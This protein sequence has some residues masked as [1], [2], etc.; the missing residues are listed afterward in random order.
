MNEEPKARSSINLDELERQLREASRKQAF[1]ASD[2]EKF[3][4][5]RQVDSTTDYSVASEERSDFRAGSG[6]V[7]EA[8]EVDQH[9]ES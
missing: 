8:P 6:W 4:A 5:Q 7:E 2:T 3:V 1:R 9:A